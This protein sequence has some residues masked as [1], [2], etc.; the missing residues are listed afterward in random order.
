MV[1]TL[2]GL[3]GRLVHSSSNTLPLVALTGRDRRKA[4]MP[5]HYDAMQFRVCA[6]ARHV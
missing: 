6:I 4:W 2:T 3:G 1:Q 5:E